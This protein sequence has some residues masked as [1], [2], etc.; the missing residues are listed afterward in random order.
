MAKYKRAKPQPVA[1]RALT[2]ADFCQAY[3]ISQ[4]HYFK[5]K[6]Q[7]KG[8]REMKLGTKILI[9]LRAA[10]QWEIEQEMAAANAAAS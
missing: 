7:G 4:D 9:T 10:E 8:P 5:L 6:R 3:Q 2:I 1:R